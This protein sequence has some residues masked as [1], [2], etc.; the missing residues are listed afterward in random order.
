MLPAAALGA[1]GGSPH[2]TKPLPFKKESQPSRC[3]PLIQGLC[4]RAQPTGLDLGSSPKVLSAGLSPRGAQRDTHT[5]GVGLT[6]QCVPP[7]RSPTPK[8]RFCTAPSHLSCSVSA[9][10]YAPKL[11]LKSISKS[12][13][14]LCWDPVPV[15]MQNGFITSYTIFWANSTAEV[16]SE[17]CLRHCRHCLPSRLDVLGGNNSRLRAPL[18]EGWGEPSRDPR[19]SAGEGHPQSS[20]HRTN[21]PHISQVPP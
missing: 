15:E 17:S 5:L 2:T 11:H 1:L 7:C 8:Q 10:S 4:R 13:A 18:G 16:S 14:E 19:G 20:P 3:I 12:D 6:T 21:S 9:P